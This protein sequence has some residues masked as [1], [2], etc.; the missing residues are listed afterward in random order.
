MK[1]TA[2]QFE[3]S[4][5]VK[6]TKREISVLMQLSAMHYDHVCKAAGKCGGFLWGIRN[7]NDKL[8]WHDLD[9]L[10]KICEGASFWERSSLPAIQ[11]KS[12]IG[13]RLFGE[14][15]A[16]MKGLGFA[17]ECAEPVGQA[18]VVQIN[19]GVRR[20]YLGPLPYEGKGGDLLEINKEL[21]AP[22]WEHPLKGVARGD[23]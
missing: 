14:I 23:R 4:A 3:P 5:R 2:I 16:L 8:T 19:T 7:G 20:T 21:S 22:P 17:R 13:R 9:I 1:L 12:E 6:F 11:A 15:L 10:G 18:A